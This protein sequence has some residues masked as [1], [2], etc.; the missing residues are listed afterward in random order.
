MNKEVKEE[1][2][3]RTPLLSGVLVL[4][5]SAAALVLYLLTGKNAFTPSLSVTVIAFAALA[6][7]L[8]L[9]LLAAG[10]AFAKGKSLYI[11]HLLQVFVYLFAL[12][13]WV[14]LLTNNANY[15]ASV[16]V[17]IDGTKLT[18]AFL[19]NMVLS[20]VAWIMS[21][22]AAVGYRKQLAGPGAAAASQAATA[23]S[24]KAA[25]NGEIEKEVPS[26]E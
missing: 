18:P 22:A 8:Q 6:I 14:F 10:G 25:G 16:A 1:S 15:L 4:V 2:G 9:I 23:S 11:R 13:S 24:D 7:G 21:I 20:A 19:A 5:F 26:H 17:G 12:L 3:K